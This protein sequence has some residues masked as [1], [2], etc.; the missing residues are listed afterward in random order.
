MV[1]PPPSDV[2]VSYATEEVPVVAAAGSADHRDR[3]S[4]GFEKRVA[5]SPSIV[6]LPCIFL[7][8]PASEVIIGN[9]IEL[10]PS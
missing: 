5:V 3:S 1:G 9:A 8:Y 6:G 10:K 7:T 4:F 2:S